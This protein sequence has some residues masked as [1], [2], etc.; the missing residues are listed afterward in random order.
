MFRTPQTLCSWWE[1]FR[2]IHATARTGAKIRRDGEKI[3]GE[4]WRYGGTPLWLRVAPTNLIACFFPGSLPI[5]G[6]QYQ[7]CGTIL[8]KCYGSAAT[9]MT[10][11]GNSR[12]GIQL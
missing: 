6:Y 12:G 5:N 7:G 8:E 10:R 3:N 4:T 2:Q 9:L 1:S 11:H